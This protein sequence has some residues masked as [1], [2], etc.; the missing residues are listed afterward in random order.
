[1]ENKTFGGAKNS[2]TKWAWGRKYLPVILAVVL[3]ICA[4]VGGTMAWLMAK[5]EPIV[6]TFTYG[7]I[8]ID[9]DESTGDEYEMIPG[10]DIDKDPVVTV[11]ANSIDCWLFIKLEKSDN[12]DD[13]LTYEIAEG[14]T[15]LPGY[16]GVYY[17]EVSQSDEDQEFH[18]LLNDQV[19]VLESVT[20]E[21]LNALDA[22]PSNANYPTLT[23]TAY[24]VQRAGFDTA[25]EAWAVVEQEVEP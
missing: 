13:F 19:H 1:M 8:D 21:Q 4:V 7:D 5:S 25:L 6:N 24:A 10:M 3:G 17:R 23:V 11:E 18:V 2:S 14:W 9:V 20:K 16:E 12:F 22:D 15:P